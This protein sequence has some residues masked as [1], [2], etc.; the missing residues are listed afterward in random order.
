MVALEDQFQTRID[1]T[2]FA[3]AKTLDELRTL[4]TAAP[5]QAEVAEPVDFPSWN[6][7][8]IVRIIRRVEPGDVDPAARPRVRV[9]ARRRARA[10][11][12]I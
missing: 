7:R 6:R 10:P 5:Q 1:E 11:R 2:K 4:V 9:G 12:G 3:G 8:P